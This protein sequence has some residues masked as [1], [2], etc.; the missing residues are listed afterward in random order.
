MLRRDDV[1]AAAD[2]VVVVDIDVTAKIVG[3][4]ADIVIVDVVVVTV[5]VGVVADV[6][7]VPADVAVDVDDGETTAFA[8]QKCH[9]DNGTTFQC[10]M[11]LPGMFLTLN[12]L[13][14]AYVCTYLPR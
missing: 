2:V 6:V 1:V 13:T 14:L 11:L 8:I 5:G 12:S 10:K 4:V 3:D 9:C 7:I